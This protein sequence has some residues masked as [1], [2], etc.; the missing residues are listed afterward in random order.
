ME[1]DIQ[2]CSTD[3]YAEHPSQLHCICI[4]SAINQSF[5]NISLSSSLGSLGLDNS[6]P[7]YTL[8][9]LWPPCPCR[10][11]WMWTML[12][13]FG[14]E[15]WLCRNRLICCHMWTAAATKSL[16]ERTAFTYCEAKG[17]AGRGR[18]AS[19]TSCGETLPPPSRCPPHAGAPPSSLATTHSGQIRLW[20]F[21]F[22]VII[23]WE[24][25]GFLLQGRPG[26][27]TQRTRKAQS[28]PATLVAP[29]LL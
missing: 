29:L 21:S 6:G 12:G 25:T 1:P 13:P 18:L 7:A 14:K 20:Q 15:S 2:C 5:Y 27:R 24:Q 19:T 3:H 17:R 8:Q 26:E 28:V 16:G 10:D 9:D 4:Q 23:P 22:L 11:P